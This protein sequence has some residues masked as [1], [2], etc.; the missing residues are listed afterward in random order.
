M[1]VVSMAKNI[2]VLT[3]CLLGLT[4]KV[5]SGPPVTPPPPECEDFL[6]G[7]GWITGTPSGDFANFGVG[8][9]VKNGEL[10]GHLNYI[11]HATG[12]H[13]KATAV[14]GYFFVDDDPNCRI[15][16]YEVDIDGE[17]GTAEVL[18]CDN[19]EPGADDTFTIFLSNGYE[20]G[21]DLAAEHAGG[22]NI[23]LHKGDCQ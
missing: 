19:G 20:A 4:A 10:W 14:T 3:A 18:V 8:G 7:G 16:D 13:V 1:K 21:G 12:M 15:I 5:H 9:G 17:P 2:S 6:T 22:G 23:Q 11:D